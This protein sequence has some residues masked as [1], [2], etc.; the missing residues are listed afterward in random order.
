MFDSIFPVDQEKDT[1]RKIKNVE[2]LK[3]AF[4]NCMKAPDIT[5]YSGTA[6]GVINA[7][8]DFVDHTPP[9]RYTD[10]YQ[11]NNW[12]KIMVGHPAVDAMY[13]LLSAKAA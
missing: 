9:I 11:E 5:Q 13:S 3:S 6:W 10:S 4:F 2:Y 1:A 12:G 7:M 8:T